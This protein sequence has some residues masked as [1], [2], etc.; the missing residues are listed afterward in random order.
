M[1]QALVASL[2]STYSLEIRYLD[3]LTEKVQVEDFIIR[4]LSSKHHIRVNDNN[5]PAF[6]NERARRGNP[7]YKKLKGTEF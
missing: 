7:L 1:D 5:V 6:Q 4:A 2:E 3:C